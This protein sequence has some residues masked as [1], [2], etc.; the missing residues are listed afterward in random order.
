MSKDPQ[1][2]KSLEANLHGSEEQLRLAEEASGVGTFELDL[3]T[4]HWKCSEQVVLLFSGDAQSQVS[5]FADVERAIFVDDVPK[6]HAA[7]EE[8]TRRGIYKVEFR[9]THTDGSVHWLAGKG[10]IT[11][12][13]TN[14]ARWLRGAYYEITDRKVL[15]ARL[16]A[17]NET[18]EARVGE[19]SS[20]ARALEVL[21]RTGVS[22]AGELELERLVQMERHIRSIL[23]PA[24]LEKHS[25]GFLCP[26]IL[27]SLNPRSA[28]RVSSVRTTLLQ[29]F[30]TVRIH[31]TMGCQ[32]A[33]YLFAAISRYLSRRVRARC[34]ADCFSAIRNLGCSLTEPSAL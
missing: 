8:A 28:A 22:V 17:L 21:N 27:Q 13:D 6:L 11:T 33:I 29:I 7:I 26:A 5:S 18:L 2:T 10:R 24:H 3:A 34:S 20:E 14:R 32:R 30:D 31:L 19:V 9:V 4:D 23:S 25:P 15:E 16:L 1:A 12:D